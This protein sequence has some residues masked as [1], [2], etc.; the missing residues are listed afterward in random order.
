MA[1]SFIENLPEELLL[2]VGAEML[3]SLALLQ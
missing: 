1:E 2:Q 3:N